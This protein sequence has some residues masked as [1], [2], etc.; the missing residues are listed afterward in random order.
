MRIEIKPAD[1]AR[2]MLLIN[3]ARLEAL[4][5]AATAKTVNDYE[6]A[7]ECRADLVLLDDIITQVMEQ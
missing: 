2:F 6:A 7:Q 3:E 4:R 5:N 1:T